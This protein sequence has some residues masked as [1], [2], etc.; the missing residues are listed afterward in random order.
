MKI[1]F[2]IMAMAG[3][4]ACYF[5]AS[6]CEGN[7]PNAKIKVESM[8]IELDDILVGEPAQVIAR[9][10]GDEVPLNTFSATRTIS[11]DS[12]K[13]ITNNEMEQILDYQEQIVSAN[14]GNVTIAITSTDSEATVVRDFSLTA[15]GFTTSIYIEQYDL[16][17]PLVAAAF[18]A[19]A[20]EL[21]MKLVMSSFAGLNEVTFNISGLTDIPTGENLNVTITL[22][23]VIFEAEVV[24]I[25]H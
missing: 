20:N 14:A 10:D 8:V 24:K 12:I 16:G 25:N 5:V 7:T 22:G 17:T 11:L 13:G 2:Q 18:T 19:F 4:F 9:G 23:D 3:L 15:N 21:L 6:S 1:K